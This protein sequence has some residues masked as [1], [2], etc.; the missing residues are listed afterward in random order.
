M[1]GFDKSDEDVEIVG[2][3]PGLEELAGQFWPVLGGW[4][5]N[6][7]RGGEPNYMPLRPAVDLYRSAV[8][9]YHMAGARTQD[10]LSPEWLT[11]TAPGLEAMSQ[12]ERA[13][14]ERD[15]DRTQSELAMRYGSYGQTASSPMVRAMAEAELGAREAQTAREAQRQFG[16]YQQKLGMMPNLLQMARQE[17]YQGAQ[18]IG[19]LTNDVIQAVLQYLALAKPTP[20]TTTDQWGVRIPMNPIGGSAAAA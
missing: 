4:I 10:F 20:M 6:F 16:A 1:M 7:P 19:G 17:P 5:P 2:G 8:P 18:M 12:A 15:I 3:L 14:M 9:Q 13:R 11:G